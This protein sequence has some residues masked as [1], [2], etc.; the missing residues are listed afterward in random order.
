MPFAE[1]L[2]K[3]LELEIEIDRTKRTPDNVNPGRM[4]LVE[5]FNDGDKWDY[6]FPDLTPNFKIALDIEYMGICRAAL[7][8]GVGFH[9]W[10]QVP[11]DKPCPPVQI[12]EKLLRDTLNIGP[13]KAIYEPSLYARV[14]GKLYCD[15]F[16]IVEIRAQGP[17]RMGVLQTIY[18]QYQEEKLRHPGLVP[19]VTIKKEWQEIKVGKDIKR[20]P[21]PEIT[22]WMKRPNDLIA[23]PPPIPISKKFFIDGALFPDDKPASKG[24]GGDPELPL[25]EPPPSQPGWDGSEPEPKDREDWT[26]EDWKFAVIG[27]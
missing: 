21:V 20:L 26:E 7:Y 15:P 1:P 2:V 12:N 5:P 22:E 14:R 9:V 4:V 16:R 3:A 25:G 13:D 27:S 11:A 24:N 18:D 8:T 6:R 10:R 17:I 19:V 23:A